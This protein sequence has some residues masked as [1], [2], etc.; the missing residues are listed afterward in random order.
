MDAYAVNLPMVDLITKLDEHLVNL[1]YT[2]NT[3]RHLRQ[4]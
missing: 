4:A 1:G 3:L 2:A